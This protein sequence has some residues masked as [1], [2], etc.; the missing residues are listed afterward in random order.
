MG[1]KNPVRSRDNNFKSSFKK[2]KNS[3]TL[4][5]KT[6]L[7]I[8][9]HSVNT[10]KASDYKVNSKYTAKTTSKVKKIRQRNIIWFNPSFNKIIR[11]NVAKIFRLLDKTFPRTNRH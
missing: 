6:F 4:T 7:P 1:I 2:V 11:R 9:F 3:T 8:L 5:G 10:L